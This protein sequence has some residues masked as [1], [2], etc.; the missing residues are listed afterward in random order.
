[1]RD[2][3]LLQKLQQGDHQAFEY[4][5]DKY[6]KGVYN[7]CLS[8]VR[9]PIWSDDLTQ[10]VFIEV[11]ESVD[12]FR[13]RSSLW[14]WVYRIAVNKSLNFERRRKRILIMDSLHLA[15]LEEKNY[16]MKNVSHPG[17]EDRNKELENWVFQKIRDLP[18]SQRI[19]FTLNKIDGVKQKDIGEIMDLSI[20]AVES[21][22]FR[23]KNRLKKLAK[24]EGLIKE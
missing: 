15:N 6:A 3:E 17:V 4:L 1:M 21:L 9:D 20:S 12:R 8:F 22:I 23:A 10:E 16:W 13:G 5:V 7:L 19:A 24:K 2:E 11:F 18:R 14:T